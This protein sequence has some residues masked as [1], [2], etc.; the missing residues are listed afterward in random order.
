[1]GELGLCECGCG[2]P[3]AIALRNC[4]RW[5]WIKGEPKRFVKG[6][7]GRRPFDERFWEKV[8]DRAGPENCWPWLAGHD[9]HGYGVFMVGYPGR[10]VPRKAHRIAWELT[11]A[12][13]IPKGLCA[14]HECDN[15][16]CVNPAHLFLGT[17]KD[18]AADMLRKG[19]NRP[20]PQRGEANHN[21]KLTEE[22]VR[23]IRHL[24]KLGW[25]RSQ[26]ATAAR[27][28]ERSVKHV[29]QGETWVHVS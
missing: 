15:P 9:I 5:G 21:A 26:I 4:K 17:L 1:M 19:R 22:R 6:H 28:S 3:T 24:R 18:N 10:M 12:T 29:V 16:P 27:T 7:N 25:S 14:L 2:K 8:D 20:N 13:H 11:H 23:L